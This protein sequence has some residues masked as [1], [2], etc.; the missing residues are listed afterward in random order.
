MLAYPRF[1]D[2]FIVATDASD[3][4]IGGVL[5]QMHDGHEWLLAYWSRQLQKAETNYSNIE[6]EALAVVGAAKELYP[7]LYG[8]PLKLLTDHNPSPLLRELRTQ[9]VVSLAD[10]FLQQFNFTVEYLKGASDT[11]ADALS[12]RPPNPTASIAAIATDVPCFHQFLS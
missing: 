10:L 7:Y 3:T 9:G 1:S 5:S 12:R 11:N 8:F 4:A 2:T 6:R